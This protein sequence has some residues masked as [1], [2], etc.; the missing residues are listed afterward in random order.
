MKKLL[1]ITLVMVLAFS[2]LTA[3]GGNADTDTSGD[4]STNPTASQDDNQTS[5]DE[6]IADLTTVD[7]WLAYWELTEDDLKCA[8]FTRL[9]KTTTVI[10]TG[11]IEEVGAYINKELT[12]EEVR[13]WLEK[14]ISKLNSMSEEGKLANI[15]KDGEE[16]TA[17][18]IMEQN[19][20]IGSGDFTYKGKKVNAM[21]SVMP[22]YLD[23]DDPN[24]AMAA[25]TL[26]LSY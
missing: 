25:C 2:L 18:Y 6:T 9:D 1:A 16:L 7:G 10:S 8:N 26:E 20:R 17:D 23:S 12:D 14:V 15:L 24:D 19:M 3:C 13:A 11:E 21:I 5:D 22:G 4:D